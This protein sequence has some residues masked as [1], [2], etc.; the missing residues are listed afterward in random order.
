M[1][2]MN[3]ASL[4]ED[5]GK[6]I[7]HMEVG[8]PST[9]GSPEALKELTKNILNNNLGYSVALGLPELRRAIADL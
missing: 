3:E 6:S 9:G 1:D 8:Q 4:L 7:I 2:V 5:R